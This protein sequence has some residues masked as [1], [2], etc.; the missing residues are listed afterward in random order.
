MR[1][2]IG[3]AVVLSLAVHGIAAAAL[4]PLLAPRPMPQQ[5]HARSTLALATVQVPQQRATEREPPAP[6]ADSAATQGGRLGAG[7]VPRGQAVARPATGPRAAALTGRATALPALAQTQ[8]A[9]PAVS[10]TVALQ[11]PVETKELA[12]AAAVRPVSAR[13]QNVED[14]SQTTPAI[15]T[16]AAPA[17]QV[18]LPATAALAPADAQGPSQQ[19]QRADGAQVA[20]VLP[21]A[22][23]LT[24]TLGWSGAENLT[25]DPQ[26]LATLEAFLSPQTDTARAVRDSMTRI[27][28]AP[29]CARV[30]TVF[31]PDTGALELRGHLPDETLRVPLLDRMRAQVGTALPLRD[32]LRILPP[33]QCGTLDAITALGLPQSEEQLTDSDLVGEAAQVR[34]YAFTEGDRLTIDLT[35]PDYPAYVYV[36]YFDAE[37]QVIHLRPNA[38]TPLV[39]TAQAEVFSIGR[40][41]DLDLRI[42]PPFGQDIAVAFASSVPLYDGLRPLVEPAAPYLAEMRARIAEARQAHPDFRGEW[43][44]LFVA[45]SAR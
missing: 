14:A 42:A 31:D 12:L 5:D 13:L 25:L 8:P 11:T 24:A 16:P 35:G 28:G 18:A 33:P 37:G 32:A 2:R 19:G 21:D 45:T 29:P 6:K 44:Y 4:L 22:A 43:A 38:Q 27:M 40:G 15:I 7:P 20:A 1:G 10:P 9:D 36:D 30:Q 39:Q 41:D 26:S 17:G 34:E 3:L 23:A